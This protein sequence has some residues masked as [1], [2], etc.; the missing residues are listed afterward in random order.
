M[1]TI[2]NLFCCVQALPVINSDGIVVIENSAVG[3]PL[4]A[5]CVDLATDGA[6]LPLYQPA[7]TASGASLSTIREKELI[8]PF[9]TTTTGD[10]SFSALTPPNF[11]ID[12][13]FDAPN[14]TLD[15]QTSFAYTPQTATDGTDGCLLGSFNANYSFLESMRQFP[16][17]NFCYY[18][19]TAINLFASPAK[20]RLI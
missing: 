19:P 16:A 1:I 2:I 7:S 17:V 11:V 12:Y 10:F 9:G 6:F 14:G 18:H 8:A 15:R 4:S 5:I 13:Q 20:T 3:S